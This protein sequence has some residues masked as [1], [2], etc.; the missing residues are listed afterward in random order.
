MEQE[1]AYLGALGGSQSIAWEGDTLRINTE[2]GTLVYGNTAPSLDQPTPTPEATEE[3]PAPT[4]ETPTAEPTTE[5]TPESPT[6]TPAVEPTEAAQPVALIS[7]PTEGQAN[8]PITFDG[9]A[10]TPQG[11]IT[12]YL[13]DF[14]DGTEPVEGAL[15]EHTYTAAGTYTVTL[16]VSDADGQMGSATLE[17]TI[18]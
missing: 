6:E 3:T 9:S 17:I 7:A 5:G 15:V 14:G 10:S 8:Q 11:G 16:T 2:L 1:S 18:S 12:S 4:S 13:W